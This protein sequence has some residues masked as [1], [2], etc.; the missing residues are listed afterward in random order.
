MIVQGRSAA[1]VVL[2]QG[3]NPPQGGP[4]EQGEGQGALQAVL[5]FQPER[6]QKPKAQLPCR[7]GG[8]CCQVQAGRIV[9]RP[10]HP[11]FLRVEHLGGLFPHGHPV[12]GKTAGPLRCAA[13]D[14]L[15]AHGLDRTDDM[16]QK[17]RGRAEEDEV[18]AQAV[19]FPVLQ[20]IRGR[21]VEH[22]GV[23]PGGEARSVQLFRREDQAVG[24]VAGQQ[25]GGAV[26]PFQGTGHAFQGMA[27]SAAQGRTFK[28]GQAGWA[29]KTA[30]EV[31]GEQRERHGGF[32]S[33]RG[34]GQ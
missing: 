9:R 4:D 26:L 20:L 19:A 32:W 7:A 10:Q 23:G 33:R 6:G 15:L 1:A 25:A 27:E 24:T 12:Q 5:V 28:G 14:A 16:G 13:A 22:I 8:A 3:R 18:E 34:N 31:E 11:V 2:F 17:L 21:R 29:E 30:V